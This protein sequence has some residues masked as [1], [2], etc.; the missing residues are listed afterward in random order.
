MITNNNDITKIVFGQ[1]TTNILLSG[2]DQ[3]CYECITIA[4]KDGIGE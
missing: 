2:I 4:I 1:Y 3:T